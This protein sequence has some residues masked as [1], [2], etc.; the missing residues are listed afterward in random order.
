MN[1][2]WELCHAFRIGVATRRQSYDTITYHSHP[3]LYVDFDNFNKPPS[4]IW[5]EDRV[6]EKSL[7]VFTWK[8]IKTLDFAAFAVFQH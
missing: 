8:C 4:W 2:K 7:K 1:K 5:N 6:I 3:A